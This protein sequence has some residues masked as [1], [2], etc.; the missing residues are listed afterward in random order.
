[1]PN[2]VVHEFSIPFP[3][4]TEEL[5]RIISDTKRL[6]ELVGNPKYEVY[7]VLR[8]DGVVD[9][10]GRLRLPGFVIEWLEVPVNWIEN[11]WFEQVRRFSNG[12]V[13]EL[14]ARFEITEET[15]GCRCNVKL[16]ASARARASQL[17][18][19]I[20]TA[21]EVDLWTLRPLALAPVWGEDERA[22]IEMF[23]QAV[24]E[25]LLESRWDLLCPR[26]RVSKEQSLRAAVANW[27]QQD[28]DV[29]V[30]VRIGVHAG[31]SIS[32]N[33]NERL[34]Y[35][36]ST[37]NMAARLEEQARPARSPC[38]KRSSTMSRSSHC[39]ANSAFGAPVQRSR[40][41]TSQ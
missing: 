31:S 33:L 30:G 34:D 2:S 32:V 37:V 27:R 24:K 35:Y 15:D 36:G 12:P 23:L 6:N 8:D 11:R 20:L 25:R 9:V 29:D 7:E 26:C 13:L 22:M 3:H 1:M 17:V 5:W 40:A 28:A 39:L 38:P 10:F 19:H 4:S 16:P 14:T 41:S 21:Q 18:D